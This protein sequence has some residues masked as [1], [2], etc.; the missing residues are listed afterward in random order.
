MSNYLHHDQDIRDQLLE[1]VRLT[2]NKYGEDSVEARKFRRQAEWLI[3][4]MRIDG[5]D[6][7]VGM[8]YCDPDLTIV[9]HRDSNFAISFSDDYFLPD[10]KTVTSK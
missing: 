9:H 8:D 4:R 3:E 1:W 5:P 6:H 7:G 10:Q 2:R